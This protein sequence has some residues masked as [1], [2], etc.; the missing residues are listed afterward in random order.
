[1]D[2]P[3]V[4]HWKRKAEHFKAERDK[5][6]EQLAAK[7]EEMAKLRLVAI[8]AQYVVDDDCDSII[9]PWC[10]QALKDALV[11]LKQETECQ[12]KRNSLR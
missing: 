10:W 4:E 8:H 11:A 2:A 9:H 6:H 7:D 5:L 12:D 3:Q 1:M